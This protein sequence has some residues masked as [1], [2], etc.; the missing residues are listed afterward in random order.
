MEKISGNS[1]DISKIGGSETEKSQQCILPNLMCCYSACITHNKKLFGS[2]RDLLSCYVHIENYWDR[3]IIYIYV[4]PQR[5]RK[6]YFKVGLQLSNVP[7]LRWQAANDG[8]LIDTFPQP[9][10][11]GDA[12]AL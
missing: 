12:Q 4:M 1:N 8:G 7:P 3:R 9:K 6:N 5:N 11:D 10:V 2:L